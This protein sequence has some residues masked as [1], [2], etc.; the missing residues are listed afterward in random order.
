MIF[1][2]VS[3]PFF[4]SQSVMITEFTLKDLA[5][6]YGIHYVTLARR[7]K[8]CGVDFSSRKGR[9]N[10]TRLG[11]MQLIPYF[12]VYGDRTGQS[13]SFFRMDLQWN[14]LTFCSAVNQAG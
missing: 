14:G 12:N 11:Y 9:G 10:K 2:T 8:R 13:K 5:L 7:L 3:H 1:S 4:S 6:L